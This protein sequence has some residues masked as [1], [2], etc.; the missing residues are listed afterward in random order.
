MDGQYSPVATALPSPPCIECGFNAVCSSKCSVQKYPHVGTTMIASSTGSLRDNKGK[1][2]IHWVPLCVIEAIAAVL[3]KNSKPGGG[4]YPEHNWQ[5]GNKH[6]VP[7]DSLLRHAHKLAD[8]EKIDPDD[9]LRHSW[10]ILCNAAFLVFY[11]KFYPEMD[12]MPKR[13]NAPKQEPNT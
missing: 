5:K 4:K 12:D 10:K 3:W 13:V 11:E 2:P 7:L 8:G 9:Q 1:L 6:S